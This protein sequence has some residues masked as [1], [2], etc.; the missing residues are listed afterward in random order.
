MEILREDGLQ[1]EVE[2]IRPPT[3]E[4]VITLVSGKLSL[5]SIIN[6]NTLGPQYKDQDI[7]HGFQKDFSENKLIRFD[8]LNKNKFTVVHSQCQ[9]TYNIDGFKMKNQDKTPISEDDIPEI[10]E[11]GAEEADLEE[12]WEDSDAEVAGGGAVKDRA[13]LVVA[14][15][16]D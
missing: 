6:D 10:E 4:E 16:G 3:N 11:V 13:V 8:L 5:F 12:V 9:V 2:G 1:R 15:E 14:A 7:V